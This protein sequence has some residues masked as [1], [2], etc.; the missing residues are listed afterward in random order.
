MKAVIRGSAG[1]EWR[2][3]YFSRVPVLARQQGFAQIGAVG[4]FGA[5]GLDLRADPLVVLL[6]KLH[7]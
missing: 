5:P 7:G 6:Q 1:S 2:P 4:E 3:P